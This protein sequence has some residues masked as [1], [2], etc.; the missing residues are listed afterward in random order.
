ML[1]LRRSKIWICSLRARSILAE[2]SVDVATV[3]GATIT[4]V[5]AKAKQAA[6]RRLALL[7][8]QNLLQ[9]PDLFLNL[10]QNPF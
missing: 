1:K 6:V 3:T 8:M 4:F 9:L 2:Q 5:A 7:E 10:R